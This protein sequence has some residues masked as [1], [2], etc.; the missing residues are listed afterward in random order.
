MYICQITVE[1]DVVVSIIE[2][3]FDSVQIFEQMI[4]QIMQFLELLYSE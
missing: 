4:S 1:G 3:R 2:V